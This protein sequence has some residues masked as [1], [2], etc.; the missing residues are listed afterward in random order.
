MGLEIIVLGYILEP[1]AGISLFLTMKTYNAI[2]AYLFFIGAIGYTVGL[3]LYLIK[4][5]YLAILGDV[6]KLGGLA[7][8]VEVRKYEASN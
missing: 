4:F 7:Y 2:S 1:I 8:F 6:V 5:P 3:P